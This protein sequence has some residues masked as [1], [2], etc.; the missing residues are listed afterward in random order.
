MMSIFT[1]T[2]AF[3]KKDCLR[4]FE[5][6]GK[7]QRWIDALAVSCLGGFFAASTGL[8]MN[9]LALFG[10]F[11]G[12]QFFQ[13]LGIWLIIAAFPLAI[14]GAHALDEIAEINR[15]EKRKMIEEKQRL[16]AYRL[17]E[18]WKNE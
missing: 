2:P 15:E 10:V 16:D 1:G 7:K 13:T 17:S 12:T 14:F 8:V 3:Q 6:G 9:G 11:E 4:A 5:K 18:L